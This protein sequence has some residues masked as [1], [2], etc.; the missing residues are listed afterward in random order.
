MY[1]KDWVGQISI[2]RCRDCEIFVG[3]SESITISELERCRLVVAT[4]SLR[5]VKCKNVKVLLFSSVPSTF[6]DCSGITLGCF[7]YFYFEL[8]STYV[9]GLNDRPIRPCEP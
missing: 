4:G 2:S 3:P 9:S 7:D 5:A 6:E 1:L 8:R